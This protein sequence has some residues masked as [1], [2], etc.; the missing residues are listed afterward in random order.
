MGVSTV[1]KRKPSKLEQAKRI[2]R[3]QVKAGNQR[4]KVVHNAVKRAG[5]STRTYRTAR[6][7]MGTKAVRHNPRGKSRGRGTWY[8]SLG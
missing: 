6:K 1:A 2:I 7:Q 8:V 4:A 3:S 5:I